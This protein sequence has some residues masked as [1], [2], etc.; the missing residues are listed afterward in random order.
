MFYTV[1][2]TN[3][4]PYMQWQ[5]D[6][7]EY[8]WKRV[9][10][11][12]TLIRLVA[13][14]DP[15]NLPAQKFAHC[16]ATKLWDVH[17][18]TGDSYPIYN[19]PASLLEWV[20]REKPEGTVLLLDPDCVFRSPVTRHA[21]PGFPASQDWID[22]AT[23]KPSAKSPFGLGAKFSFLKDH[24]ARPGLSIEAVMI[25]TL[26][27]TSDLRKICARWLELCGKIRDHYRNSE[28]LP[29]WESDMFAYLAACAEYG[30]QHEPIS[31]G[32]CTNWPPE[33]VPEAPIIHYCQ[34]IS[35]K[36]GQEIFGKHS[37]T[38]W[39]R[40]DTSVEPE[41]DYGRD[42]VEIVNAYIDDSLGIVRPPSL[43][44]CPI[45]RKGVMEGRVIDEML[46]ELPA[47]G[48]SLWL[49][50]SGKAIWELCDGIRT[51]DEIG[52]E[53]G[54]RFT[55]GERDFSAD[56]LSTVGQLHSVGFLKLQ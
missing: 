27:H 52:L 15:Q 41:Q 53:L 22:F 42:L 12:G 26:I 7:L 36:N 17:P 23:G 48:R 44:N 38:P 1:F 51:I 50:I 24:C 25:P 14:D 29:V 5:S 33:R 49:N 32:I 3:N 37:Y 45:Q 46:L 18:E 28:G 11:E 19:K 30:L 13:T 20:F 56:V 40:L 34:V 21:A 39:A 16:F 35:G 55:A 9:E 54:K 8:S 10:Q 2:S 4:T 43:S 47:E 6:L 31:L